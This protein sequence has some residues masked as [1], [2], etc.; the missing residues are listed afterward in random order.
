MAK[1]KKKT[2]TKGVGDDM[3]SDKTPAGWPIPK[4]VKQEFI[5]FCNSKGSMI[6]EDC[7][8]ALMIWRF[9]PAQIREWAK[10]EAKGIPA[11]DPKFWE[12]FEYGLRLGLA[13]Q[14][15]NP[16]KDQE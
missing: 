2:K 13:S 15:Q 16:P 7:A 10:L 8:G 4:S 5:N 11:V 9:L 1:A 3:K 14:L 12:D 6:Q